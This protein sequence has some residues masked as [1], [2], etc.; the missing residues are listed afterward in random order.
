MIKHRRLPTIH[1]QQ[2]PTECGLVCLQAAGAMLGIRVDIEQL[3]SE[4]F[5]SQRGLRVSHMATVA[6]LLGFEATPVAFDVRGSPCIHPCTIVLVDSRHFVLVAH[7]S[8]GRFAVFDPAKGWRTMPRAELIARMDGLGIE[9]RSR[10]SAPVAPIDPDHSRITKW[11]RSVP[12]LIRLLATPF[13]VGVA[14]MLIVSAGPWLTKITIDGAATGR[15]DEALLGIAGVLAAGAFG[16]LATYVSQRTGASVTAMIGAQLMSDLIRRLHLLPLAYFAR[17]PATA[18]VARLRAVEAIRSLAV[19][20][21]ATS[22]NQ[23]ILGVASLAMMTAISPPMAAIA[24]VG[25]V[26]AVAAEK[27]FQRRLRAPGEAYATATQRFSVSATESIGAM[28]AIR[29]AQVA[30]QAEGR[31]QRDHADAITTECRWQRTSAS[32]GLMRSGIMLAYTGAMLMIGA[33]LLS[34]R[35]LTFGDYVAVTAYSGM[36]AAALSGIGALLG[37]A[38]QLFHADG[39]LGGLLVDH[40]AQPP[41]EADAASRGAV[42]LNSVSFAYSRFDPPVFEGLTLSIDAGE[43]VAI[44][45]PSGAG[46]TTLAKLLVGA[47][48]PSGGDIAVNG[49]NVGACGGVAGVATVMQNDSLLTA[50]VYD[51][52]DLFRGAPKHR[53]EAAARMAEIHDTISS[54]PMRYDT[55]ISDGFAGL[56]GG[57]RQRILLARAL[58]SNPDIL[59]LD[60]ATS[61]L[62]AAT[63]RTIMRSIATLPITRIVFT[64][65]SESIK[66]ASRVVNLDALS[67]SSNA[68]QTDR[69]ARAAPG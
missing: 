16:A 61:A 56:S 41:T 12:G 18:I 47:V 23:I 11:L 6:E 38:T 32:N 42:R 3:K 22:I 21:A 39:R 53:V 44:V 27:C 9:L 67:N 51:N 14:G 60:E 33:A 15:H 8:S 35:Q 19:E 13:M 29:L 31:L 68:D 46:K 57:Q 26:A 10:T 45:A 1:L 50:S 34:S 59:I 2:E 7:E 30:P 49:C 5:L 66:A 43:C 48:S 52:I 20:V 28:Q 40:P 17:Q 24:L 63:E 37:G 69:L 25:A 36:V 58:L 64:H 65:R 54:L 4:G 55:V 62:D